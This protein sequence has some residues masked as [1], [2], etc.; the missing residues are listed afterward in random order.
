MFNQIC[1]ADMAESLFETKIGKLLWPFYAII[2]ITITFVAALCGRV[3][4]KVK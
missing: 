2:T 1:V 3:V 4:L